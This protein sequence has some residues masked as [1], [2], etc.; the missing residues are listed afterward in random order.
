MSEEAQQGVTF[1]AVVASDGAHLELLGESARDRQDVGLL[2]A[3]ESLREVVTVV[4]EGWGRTVTMGSETRVLFHA[5]PRLR[6]GRKL[7]PRHS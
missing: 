4:Y 5:L 3:G 1:V 7:I 2:P 6:E